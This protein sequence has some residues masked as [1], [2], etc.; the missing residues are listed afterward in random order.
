MIHSL[1]AWWR[2]RRGLPERDVNGGYDENGE[3]RRRGEAEQERNRQALENW[4][5]QNGGSADHGRERGEQNRLETHRTCFQDHVAQ[6][7]ALA[8]TV[9]DEVDEQDGVAHDDAGE[10][11]KA[12]HRS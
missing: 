12:D 3:Q 1:L 9:A 2:L 5:E 7:F 10:C 6:G 8:A 11:N 4:I